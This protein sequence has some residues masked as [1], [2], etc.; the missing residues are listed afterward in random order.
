MSL[1][2]SVL[3]IVDNEMGRHPGAMLRSVT[4]DVGRQA[5]VEIEAFRTAIDAVLKT[6]PWP[7][8]R[9]TLNL[10]EAEAECLDCGRRFRPAGY[11]AV[12][13]DCGSGVCGIVAG[14]EFRVAALT[15]SS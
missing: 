13:P 5:G 12:C 11:V 9:A 15:L 10:I 14:R 4:I 2:M 3:D 1:A 8:A 7:G 6:S